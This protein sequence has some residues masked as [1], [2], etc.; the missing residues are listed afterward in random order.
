MSAI[1]LGRC[2]I[3]RP[4]IPQY[5]PLTSRYACANTQVA[6]PRVHIQVEQQR[7]AMLWTV[8]E[9]A[10]ARL[11]KQAFLGA[12]DC[13]RRK[14]SGLILDQGNGMIAIADVILAFRERALVWK[15]ACQARSLACCWAPALGDCPPPGPGATNRPHMAPAMSSHAYPWAFRQSQPWPPAAFFPPPWRSIESS[16]PASE[17]ITWGA[18]SRRGTASRWPGRWHAR[19]SSSPSP[20]SRCA[21]SWRTPHSSLGDT[22]GGGH[23]IRRGTPSSVPEWPRWWSAIRGDCR[24]TRWASGSRRTRRGHPARAATPRDLPSLADRRR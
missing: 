21:G 16:W 14:S 9:A 10:K 3:Y 23:P 19:A 5:G 1:T 22:T 12:I 24:P 8:C 2:F 15:L 6:N 17:R 13:Q 7:I 18:P 20:R 4:P 11:I